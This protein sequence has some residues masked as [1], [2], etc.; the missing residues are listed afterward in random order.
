MI[1]CV[2]A[3]AVVRLWPNKRLPK[4]Q[5][6]LSSP[7]LAHARSADSTASEAHGKLSSL[8]RPPAHTVNHVVRILRAAAISA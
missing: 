5:C 4:Q 1:T 2:P 3:L 8:A 7:P 6:F